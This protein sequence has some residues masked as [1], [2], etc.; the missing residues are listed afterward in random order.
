MPKTVLILLAALAAALAL[1]ACG[2]DDD[3][4]A[5]VVYSGR[6]ETLVGELLKRFEATG[7]DVEVRY[8]GTSELAA[9]LLEEGSNRKAD[10]FFS[11]D[12]GALGALQDAGAL[13][14]LPQDV[15]SLVPERY[16]SKQGDWVATS[17][18]ARVIAYNPDRVKPAD[19]PKSVF[20]LT[21]PKWKGR[22]G[23]APT[24]ASFQAFVTGMRVAVG[25]EKTKAWLEGIKRNEP[26]EY[27]GNIRAVEAV[28]AG[29]VDVAL[30]NHYYLY[31]RIQEK[32]EANVKVRNHFLGNGD[33]GALVN[34]AGVGIVAG[35]KRAAQAER[36]VRFL[37]SEEAQRYFAEETFEY[38]MISAVRPPTGLPPL[39]SIQG[40]KIDLAA[41][42]PLKDTLALLSEVGLT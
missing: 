15:L 25:Q 31:E 32:G 14:P 3:G 34:V 19:L 28:D 17:G 4:D 23:I 9:Q 26:K 8:A 20:D 11:Q 10:V 6:G 18:R 21:D 13:A 38:P 24:N 37:L 33:P 22:I 30:V 36:F 27:E 12:A 7:G 16:R 39:D 42:A 5:L 2:G 35:T 1:A 41:L 40:P 29:E